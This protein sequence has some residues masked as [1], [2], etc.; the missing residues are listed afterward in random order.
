M[1]RFSIIVKGVEQLSVLKDIHMHR[2][3]YVPGSMRTMATDTAALV[4]GDLSDL[5]DWFTEDLGYKAPFREGSLLH[6]STTKVEVTGTITDGSEEKEDE[7]YPEEEDPDE[8]GD[9]LYHQMVDREV[10]DFFARDTGHW[11]RGYAR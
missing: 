10:E 2:L 9:R 1:A 6:Y 11:F 3:T 5:M 7:D 8:R 4:E